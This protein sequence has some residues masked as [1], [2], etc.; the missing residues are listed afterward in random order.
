MELPSLR[1]C[2]VRC[3]LAEIG[4]KHEKRSRNSLLI[5]WDDITD[6]RNRYL[7]NVEC[8]RAEGQKIFNLN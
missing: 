4:F 5:D 6:W 1:Q 7:C 3:L 8:Y 2:T